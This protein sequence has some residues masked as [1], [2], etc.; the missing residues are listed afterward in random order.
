M[1]IRFDELSPAEPDIEEWEARVEGWVERIRQAEGAETLIESVREWD[2]A[3]REL[4]TW[5]AWALIRYCQ[6]TTDAQASARNARL[7]ALGP[8]LQALDLRVKRAVLDS[9]HLPAATAVLG[10]QAVAL[11]T[12]DCQ[13]QDESLVQAQVREATLASEYSRLVGSARVEF[14]GQT[15]GLPQ[16]MAWLEHADRETRHQA[17]QALWGWYDS[18]APAIGDIY[19]Q[20]VALRHGMARSLGEPDFVEHGYRLMRRRGFGPDQIAAFRDELRTHVVPVVRSLRRA[21]S[22][23]LGLPSLKAWDL[24]VL[25][26]LGNPRPDPSPAVQLDQAGRLFQRLGLDE[27]FQTVRRSGVMD[28]EARAGKRPGGFCHF[29][30]QVGLPF[31]FA[32]MN[33]TSHDTKVFTHELGHA[34]QVWS[35][36]HAPLMDLIWP[37][38]D[39]AEVHSMGLELLSWPHMD[40][41]YGAQADRYRRDHLSSAI[42][43][44][45]WMAA[46]DEF[47]HR[48]YRQPDAD[49]DALWK[50]IEASWEPDLDWGDLPHGPQGRRWQAVRHL[51]STPFYMIDYALAQ[52]CALQLWSLARR[53]PEQ[54]MERY[55]A[56]CRIGG[57][58]PFLELMAGAGLRS[59]F[60]PGL[61]AE[62]MSE[63]REALDALEAL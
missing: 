5:A 16:L 7:D 14:Q 32:N 21:Q 62:L 33:G 27:F 50:E 12:L 18:N 30:P 63:V 48:V 8:P 11:W 45:P 60:E 1:V 25:D 15:L 37:T 49:H 57:E 20:L 43:A 22:Q 56:L 53:D 52:T 28:L 26:L 31:V 24:R 35:S 38:Y 39:A 13:T 55:L 19:C 34:L 9:P 10:A 44:L 46:L 17:A 3:A 41:F 29:L 2:L 23:R 51:F 47:Q 40:L 6:D 54:A 36:R 42:T 4:S 58:A 59:P 61:L